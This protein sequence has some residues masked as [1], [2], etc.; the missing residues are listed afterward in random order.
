MLLEVSC[1]E[2]TFRLTEIATHSNYK[3]FANNHEISFGVLYQLEWWKCNTHIDQ[4]QLI[5]SRTIATPAGDITDI[6]RLQADFLKSSWILY[7][8]LKI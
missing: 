6:I 4:T 2:A 3:I 1:Q 8:N 5:H 7:S